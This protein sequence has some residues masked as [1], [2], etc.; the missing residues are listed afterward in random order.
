MLDEVPA[1][2]PSTCQPLSDTQKLWRGMN[3][4][5]NTVAGIRAVQECN[6]KNTEGKA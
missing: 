4:R 5:S 3:I 6:R 1:S 2:A